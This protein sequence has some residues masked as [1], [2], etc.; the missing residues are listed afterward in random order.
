[1]R[2]VLLETVRCLTLAIVF[3]CIYVLATGL[4]PGC[5]AERARPGAHHTKAAKLALFVFEFSK[6][7]RCALCVSLQSV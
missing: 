5:A 7:G 4:M 2:N 6:V 3:G 1:M